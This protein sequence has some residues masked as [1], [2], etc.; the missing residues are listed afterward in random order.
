[1]ACLPSKNE[2]WS[3]HVAHLTRHAADFGATRVRSLSTWQ[4]SAIAS[5]AW[6]NAKWRST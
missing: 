3:A 1:V 5:G 2:I 6:S 4:R